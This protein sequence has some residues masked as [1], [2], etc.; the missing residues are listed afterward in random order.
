MQELEPMESPRYKLRNRLVSKK[1]VGKEGI[2]GSTEG[3][4][5]SKADSLVAVEAASAT[6]AEF[7]GDGEDDE[8]KK[9]DERVVVVVVEEEEEVEDRRMEPY[10]PL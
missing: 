8:D 6:A 5:V 9:E 10:G 3:A 2:E 7:E 1:R 4:V